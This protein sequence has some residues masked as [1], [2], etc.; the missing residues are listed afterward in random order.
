[1]S[2]QRLDGDVTISVNVDAY[3]DGTR[4]YHTAFRIEN[5]DGAWQQEPR[6]TIGYNDGTFSSATITLVGEGAYEG[7]TAVAGAPLQGEIWSLDGFIFER[8]TPPEPV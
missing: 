4:L 3:S 1:M 2:D 7:L 5:D 8:P 6:L